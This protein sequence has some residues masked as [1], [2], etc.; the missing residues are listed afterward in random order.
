LRLLIF[1][2]LMPVVSQDDGL[3][4][5]GVIAVYVTLWFLTVNAIEEFQRLG[6][7]GAVHGSYLQDGEV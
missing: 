5:T 3:I 4:T 7:L 1:S 6:Q 2:T